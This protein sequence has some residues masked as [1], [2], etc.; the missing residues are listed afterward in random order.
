[1]S[2]PG[3]P[4]ISVGEFDRPLYYNAGCDLSERSL[5]IVGIRPDGSLFGGKASLSQG[6]IWLSNQ[7]M[8]PGQWC[9]YVIED[10]DLNQPGWYTV[11]L[12]TYPETTE[13]QLIQSNFMV[14]AA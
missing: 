10:G 6:T 4:E 9:A 11:Q 3:A 7:V 1:M 13:G 8:M 2:Y 5:W 12:Y 14:A